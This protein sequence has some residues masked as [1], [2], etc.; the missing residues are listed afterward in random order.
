[1]QMCYPR[2]AEDQIFHTNLES[3]ISD[4]YSANFVKTI[5]EIRN[6]FHIIAF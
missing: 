2:P 6:F 3:R 5:L 4:Y 1:M